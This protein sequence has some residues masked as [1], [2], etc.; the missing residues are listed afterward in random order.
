MKAE[1]VVVAT[2]GPE[3]ARLLRG[4]PEPA[5][6]GTVCL[7]FDAPEPPV[8]GAI[9]VLDGVGEG[10]VNHLAVLSE[11]SPEYAP[12]GHHLVSASCVGLS[13]LSDE[14]LEAAVRDQMV[15]WFGGGV[16]EWRHLRTYR[17]PHAQPGQDPG[18]LDPV[19][20]EVR[21]E[22]GLFVCGDHRETASLQGAL[23]SGRRAANGILEDS[24]G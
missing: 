6:K 3:A 11:V 9:L 23:H 5:S 18:V 1:A 4:I 15:S 19:E 14:E 8:S 22:R 13:P 2:E 17:V 20:R 16:S 12:S 21:V 7:Y 10:P 24:G